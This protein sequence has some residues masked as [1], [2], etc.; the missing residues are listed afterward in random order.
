MSAAFSL[1]LFISLST[2]ARITRDLPTMEPDFKHCTHCCDPAQTVK[3]LQYINSSKRGE[4][5]PD[6]LIQSTMMLQVSSFH[7]PVHCFG[8]KRVIALAVLS[9]FTLLA[10][11]SKL[12]HHTS[13]N[14]SN[15]R[16]DE[17]LQ[18]KIYRVSRCP[19]ISIQASGSHTRVHVFPENR[20]SSSFPDYRV[21]SG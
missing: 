9:T 16:C 13:T 17:I 7:I 3:R 2:Y 11:H 5:P 14:H 15:S 6:S 1:C 21:D 8:V 18:Q 12:L 20:C 19:M 10:F 4:W